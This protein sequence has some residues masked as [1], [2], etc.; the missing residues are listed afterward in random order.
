MCHH[1]GPPVTKSE[2]S[3]SS[4]H[5]EKEHVTIFA[6]DNIPLGGRDSG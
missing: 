3:N 4:A 5:K 1:S 2:Q 6:L